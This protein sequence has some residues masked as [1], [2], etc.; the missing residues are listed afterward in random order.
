MSSPTDRNEPPQD[1]DGL[2]G[3]LQAPIEPLQA[4]PGSY[5]AI[6]RR[7]RRRRLNRAL[8]AAGAAAAVVAAAVFIPRA[9]GLLTARGN[10]AQA[11]ASPRHSVQASQR[12]ANQSAPPAP[13]TSGGARPVVPTGLTT[14]SVTFIG[15]DTGWALG[16]YAAPCPASGCTVLART[17]DTGQHWHRVGAPDAGLPDG[18]SG[19]SQVRF[20]NREDGWVFGPQLWAT[21][22]G[23]QTWNKISTYGDRVISLETAGNRAFAVFA[24]CGG[25]GSGWN[26]GCDSYQLYSAA[27]AGGAWTQVP[28]GSGP[29]TASLVLTSRSGYLLGQDAGNLTLSSGPVTGTSWGA[30]AAL[31]CGQQAGTPSSGAAPESGGSTGAAARPGPAALVA[32][33]SPSNLFLLCTGRAAS[34]T[35]GTVYMSDDGGQHW[36]RRGTAPAGGP[37][38]SVAAAAGPGP[39]GSPGSSQTAGGGAPPAAPAPGGSSGTGASGTGA[40]G[41][42]ASGTGAS[43]T[44]APGT[45]LIGTR[46]GVYLSRDGGVTWQIPLQVAGGISYLGMTDAL[47][48][49]AVPASQGAV[50]FTTDGGQSWQQSAI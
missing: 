42:S 21:H 39:G 29:G 6:V 13:E 28:G 24:R 20:L 40:S 17:D 25:T 43:G 47:Q 37:A 26:T 3:W 33:S 31:P 23:G 34:G 35:P 22:D 36:Q 9:T 38:M 7:A 2:D 32:A 49:F 15:L 44:S 48:G 18:G 41:T 1:P 11:L 5:E 10:A 12:E 16:R 4:R 50:W 19:V 45:L 14:A 46:S 27:A 8:T 30:P